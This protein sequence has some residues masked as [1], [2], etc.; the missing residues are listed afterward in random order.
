MPNQRQTRLAEET[1]GIL[2]DLSGFRVRAVVDELKDYGG[3]R[4]H[5]FR[6]TFDSEFSVF[7]FKFR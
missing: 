7:F 2:H 1:Y 4:V 6:V 3:I 5:E